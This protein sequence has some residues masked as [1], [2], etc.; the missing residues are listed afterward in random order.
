MVCTRVDLVQ[1]IPSFNMPLLRLCIPEHTQA[2]PTL[3]HRTNPLPPQTVISSSTI[4]TLHPSR[5]MQSTSMHL[6]D[7]RAQRPFGQLTWQLNQDVRILYFYIFHNKKLLFFQVYF[8]ALLTLPL[9]QQYL[10]VCTGGLVLRIILSPSL[11]FSSNMGLYHEVM[12]SIEM[13]K[14]VVFYS[15]SK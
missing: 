1:A 4:D 8:G 3:T 14:S 13:M 7:S 11:K 6:K 15:K 12:Q 10:R 2:K 5:N 9:T